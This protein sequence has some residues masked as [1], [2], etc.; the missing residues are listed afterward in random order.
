MTVKNPNVADAPTLSKRDRD[1]LAKAARQVWVAIEKRDAVVLKY[2]EAG[3]IQRE[4]GEAMGMSH[5]AVQGIGARN[6]YKRGRKPAA[7]RPSKNGAR[8]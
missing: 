7:P 3:V 2:L 1:A 4:I 5:T 6:G 8:K